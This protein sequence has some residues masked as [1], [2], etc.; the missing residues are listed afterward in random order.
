MLASDETIKV[1]AAALRKYGSPTTV[2]D[3]VSPC[4]WAFFMSDLQSKAKTTT[5]YDFN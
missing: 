2:V 5:G 1:V 3:P 4:G